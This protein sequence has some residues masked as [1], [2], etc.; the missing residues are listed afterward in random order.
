[1][2]KLKN[3]NLLRT[4][5]KFTLSLLHDRIFTSGVIKS[6]LTDI[7]DELLEA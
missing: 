1:M 3:T 7:K 4:I 5:A 2:E 6:G